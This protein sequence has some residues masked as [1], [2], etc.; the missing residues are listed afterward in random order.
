MQAPHI[1]FKYIGMI[2]SFTLVLSCGST[3]NTKK[4]TKTTDGPTVFEDQYYQDLEKNILR[5]HNLM[6]GTFIAHSG[7]KGEDLKSWAVSGGDSVVLF[8][9]PLGEVAKSGYWTYS[10]E[11]MTSLPN[12]PIYTSIKQIKQISRD[13]FNVFYYE[14]PQKMKLKDVLDK[15]RLNE[16]IKIDELVEVDK[17]T[18]YVK[19]T[20]ANFLGNSVIYED[21]QCRCMRQNSYDLKPNFYMVHTDYY[22][23]DTNEKLDKEKRPNVLVRRDMSLDLLKKIASKDDSG[24]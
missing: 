24:K 20:V 16:K 15:K 13:S 18:L 8:V 3:K 11:F 4:T 1:M 7:S 10:Y 2:L 14:V 9:T 5:L 23:K 6:Q 21:K 17:S 19:N 22:D 12:D